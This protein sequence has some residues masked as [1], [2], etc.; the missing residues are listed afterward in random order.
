MR[1]RLLTLGVMVACL[2]ALTS[3]SV[4]NPAA[5]SPS[6]K[7]KLCQNGAWEQL[8]YAN[9]GKCVQAAVRGQLVGW[10]LFDDFR[11]HPEQANPSPDQF[12][13]PDVWSYMMADD[14]GL[15]DPSSY[16]LLPG[17]DHSGDIFNVEYWYG[18]APVFGQFPD[19]WPFVLRSK[20]DYRWMTVHPG[21]PLRE[22]QPWVV[23]GWTSPI[24]GNVALAGYLEDTSGQPTP[25]SKDGVDWR[26]ETTT[27]GT[28]RLEASGSIGELGKL[29]LPDLTFDVLPGD[30][31]WLM[32]GPRTNF[33]WDQ[34]NAEVSIEV[35]GVDSA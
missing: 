16:T 33:V 5:D 32:V 11:L 28:T 30:T 23:V 12:G 1:Y 25:P 29:I 26:I 35:I 27:G 24:K 3:P 21:D 10:N 19:G 9:Q 4:A 15:M 17:Y 8:G 22:S 18:P 6:Q 20:S 14:D 7:V 31:L 2:A 13:N 34:I